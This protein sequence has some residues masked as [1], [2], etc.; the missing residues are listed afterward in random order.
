MVLEEVGNASLV[1]E[2]VLSVGRLGLWVQAVG[3][4]VVLWIIFQAIT[5]F[6]NRKRRKAIYSLKDDVARLE[7][8]IDR[9]EK[10]L[11]KRK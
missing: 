2:V 5:L 4:L 11:V 7:G 8:K 1:S 6:Y 9:I 10:V 3:L